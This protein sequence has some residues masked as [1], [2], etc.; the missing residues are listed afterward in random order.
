MALYYIR[1][2]MNQ[3]KVIC[4]ECESDYYKSRSQMT[5]LCPDCAHKLYGYPN[6]KHEFEKGNCTKCGWNGKSSKFLK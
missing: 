5:E 4:I 6:C 3:D 1:K 2:P